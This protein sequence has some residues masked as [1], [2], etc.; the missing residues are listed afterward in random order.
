M[1]QS[2]DNNSPFVILQSLEICDVCLIPHPVSTFITTN[3]PKTD[4]T[5]LANG[6]VA[7][8]VLGYAN[9]IAEAQTKLYGRSY[10][11]ENG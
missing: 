7:Y 3:D 4:P 10:T 5:I 6:T 2:A 1:I 8:K 9:S 11:K